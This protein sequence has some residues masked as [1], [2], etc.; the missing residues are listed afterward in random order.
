MESPYRIDEWAEATLEGRRIFNTGFR[1][2]GD[3]LPNFHLLKTVPMVYSGGQDE[4]VYIWQ[5]TDPR[6][7]LRIAIAERS[8]WRQAQ[9]RLREDLEIAMRG[10]IPRGSGALASVGDIVYEGREPESDI[11]A[12]V[13]FARGNVF[14][15]VRSGGN[16]VVD[17]SL[18]ARWLDDRI[19]RAPT[20]VE[21]Q[22]PRVRAR[23]LDVTASQPGEARVVVESIAKMAADGWLK[24][25]A[26]DG[27]LRREGDSLV[28]LSGSAGRTRLEAFVTRPRP[29]RGRS[30]GRG[31]AGE[32]RPQ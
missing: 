9:S 27:E 21:L 25:V 1:L 16:R 30:E 26:P 6:E 3:E 14:A 23:A 15:S 8:D 13:S 7:M 12:A 31:R 4:L 19:S 5:G 18:A 10:N 32:H 24:V 17:V 11:P 29:A 20:A 22:D 2:L 28:Y